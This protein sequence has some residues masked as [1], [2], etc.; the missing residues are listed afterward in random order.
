LGDGTV[1]VEDSGR[2]VVHDGAILAAAPHPD[3]VRLLTGGDD[4]ELK[5][6]DSCGNAVALARFGA[7]WVEH[8]VASAQ[9]GVI[10]AG[11]GKEA[12][13]LRDD[14][15]LHRFAHPSSI[16]G[17][18]L[19]AKGRRLAASHYGGATLRYALASD[20]AGVSLKWAGSHLAVTFSPEADYVVTGMQELEL[21]GWK[22]PE[23]QDL[24]MSGYAAKTK[25]FSWDRRGRWLAT[26]GADGAVVWPFQGK[27]GPMGKQAAIVGRRE[28]LV[29]RVA[30]HPRQE[31]LAIGYADGAALAFNM[32]AADDQP[33]LTALAA[34]GNPVCALAWSADGA[35]LAAADEG[36]RGCVVNI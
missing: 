21:H 26:S 5:A 17:L 29:T 32:D 36:G 25:S 9:S 4:G 27:T 18:A 12:V 2:P 14:R 3:G 8:I 13:V 19:D 24:R 6:T 7:K 34:S 31:V 30:L 1:F 22:L 28:S 16:G 33:V 11:V 20:D 15:E 10:V 23:K 35:R